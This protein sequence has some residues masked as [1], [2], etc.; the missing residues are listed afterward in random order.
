MSHIKKDL[1]YIMINIVQF[2]D[3]IFTCQIVPLEPGTQD[4]QC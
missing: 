4:T 3:Q 1:Y 2:T